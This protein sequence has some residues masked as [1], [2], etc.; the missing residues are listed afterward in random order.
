MNPLQNPLNDFE[1]IGPAP[2]ASQVDFNGFTLCEGP[3]HI[4][5]GTIMTLT[6]I[7][8]EKMNIH[9]DKITPATLIKDLEADSL[10]CVELIMACEDE[11]DVFITDEE[12]ATIKT[13]SD[14][15]RVLIAQEV[16]EEA[17]GIKP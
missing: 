6:Q 11:Y 2:L 10:D 9:P 13:V 16:T 8:A 1:N 7:I 15:A 4:L 17:L 14:L 5:K 3:G 12:A